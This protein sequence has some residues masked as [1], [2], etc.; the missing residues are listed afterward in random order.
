MQIISIKKEKHSMVKKNIILFISAVLIF[1]VMVLP[2][3]AGKVTQFTDEEVKANVS[4]LQ[5]PFIRNEGQV[6][7]DE[8]MFY[9]QTFAG[10]V[11]VTNDGSILY[12]VHGNRW[13]DEI[14]NKTVLIREKINR[15]IVSGIKGT[16]HSSTKINSFSGNDKASRKSKTNLPVYENISFSGIYKGISLELKA[17]GNN[18]EKVFTVDKNGN[19]EDIAIG[20]EGAVALNINDSNE[21]EI[22]TTAGIIKMTKP[23]AYQIVKGERIEVAVSYNIAVNGDKSVLEYGFKTGN[24]NKEYPLIIDPLIASTFAGGGN[25]EIANSLTADP[26]TGDI[27]I[28]GFTYSFDYPVTPAAFDT[29]YNAGSYDIFISRLSSDLSTLIASTFLGGSGLDISTDMT[30][31]VS[32]NIIVAGY[33][34]SDDY[35]VTAGAYDGTRNGSSDVFVSKLSGDLSTLIASTY[36]GGVRGD[37]A[38]S[39]HTDS[40]NKILITGE[41]NS[42][43][44]PVTQ[45]AYDT[46]F[47]GN[48]DAF[49]SILGN[50]LSSLSASTFIGGTTMDTAYSITIDPLNNIFITGQTYSYDF[51]ATAGSYN[52]S[53]NG[54]GFTDIFVS[55]LGSN[56]QALM[57]STLIGG[58]NYDC[59]YS[60][61]ADSSGM[62]YL[63]GWSSSPDYPVSPLANDLSHNGNADVIISMFNN[64]LSTLVSST[65]SGGTGDDYAF[66]LSLHP[67]GDLFVAGETTSTDYPVVP[68]SYDTTFNGGGRDAILSRFSSDLAILLSSTFI[69]GLRDDYAQK[70]VMD[71]SG[72]VIMTG[73]SDSIDYPVTPGAFDTSFN[74]AVL[75]SDVVISKISQPEVIPPT[76]SVILNDNDAWTK[77]PSLTLTLSCTDNPSGTGCTDMQLSQDG[78]FDTEIWE[79][80]SVSRLLTLNAGDG[81]RTVYARFRDLAGNISLEYSDS[82]TLDTTKPLVSSVVDIPDPFKPSNG[83]W[84]TV[85]FTASDNLASAC[86]A[87]L[88]I[89]NSSN[90]LIRTIYKYNIT[91]SSTGTANFIKWNGKNSAGTIVPAGVYTYRIFVKD[92]AL[93]GSVAK[94]GKVTVN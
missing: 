3:H 14:K 58:N 82:I 94:T 80:F 52:T 83:Q 33:T 2:S 37:F 50:D 43:D 31:D 19:P 91:C 10:T 79:P 74:S 89:F 29:V 55:K 16:G 64:D 39:I 18:V 53:F 28:T 70:I 77:T 60:I 27:L 85:Y 12:S 63:T 86:T 17:Y 6:N 47:N 5:I 9:T 62:I 71:S 34:D 20:V 48:W 69:G 68:G 24:Y 92:N 73:V 13:D 25:E 42:I 61:K 15:G 8:V 56:L 26:V 59:A 78:V 67:S 65:Y 23:V 81:L 38:Y 51:P 44:F 21:I 66:S 30:M 45:G 93:N 75:F 54:T 11:F 49:I 41:T 40:S 57:A 46:S 4:R 84:D 76:G 90:V 22:E 72:D 35:P 36:I 87:I 32:G 7:N 1:I 88:R